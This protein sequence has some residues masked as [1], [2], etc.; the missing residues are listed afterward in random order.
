MKVRIRKLDGCQFKIMKH[1]LDQ[2]KRISATRKSKSLT[3][4]VLKHTYEVWG[5]TTEHSTK[6]SRTKRGGSV[7]YLLQYLLCQKFTWEKADIMF[8]SYQFRITLTS[9]HWTSFF[10]LKFKLSANT[11]RIIRTRV[12]L[13]RFD[14]NT[15]F[16]SLFANFYI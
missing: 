3:K 15:I 8:L 10:R 11:V 9:F 5:D 4:R 13:H 14:R 12:D 16:F 7:L 2:C 6:R 1:L